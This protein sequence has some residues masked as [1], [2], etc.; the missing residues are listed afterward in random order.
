LS[1]HLF[2]LATTAESEAVQ[3][4]AAS[5]WLN[6]HEGMPVACPVD[7]N[8]DDIRNLTDAELAA[9]AAALGCVIRT[10]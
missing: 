1:D 8:T 5:A 10:R 2:I 3:V 6:R 9:E 4:A 7:L